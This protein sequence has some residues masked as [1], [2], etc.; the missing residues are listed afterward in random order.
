MILENKYDKQKD[1]LRKFLKEN[2]FD[3]LD[4]TNME[5]LIK[6]I[7]GVKLYLF[8]KYSIPFDMFSDLENILDNISD[9]FIYDKYYKDSSENVTSDCSI[10][11]VLF[12][13]YKGNLVSGEHNDKVSEIILYQSKSGH[14]GGNFVNNIN[15]FILGVHN[16]IN[17][18][19][20]KNDSS[21]IKVFKKVRKLLNSD[22]SILIRPVYISLYKYI[23]RDYNNLNTIKRNYDDNLGSYNVDKFE[24]LFFDQKSMSLISKLYAP[25]KISLNYSSLEKFNYPDSTLKS[26]ILFVYVKDF[27]EFISSKN[28]IRENLFIKNVRASVG[29]NQLN[30]SI[31]NTFINGPDK[32]KGDFWWIS[33]GITLIANDIN[34]NNNNQLIL[35]EPN[36]IN[37]QQTSRQLFNA[38]EYKD[39]YK[40]NP[41]YSPWKM[42]VKLFV[43]VNPNDKTSLN[44]IEKI[45]S[46]LNSQSG[47]NKNSIDLNNDFTMKVKSYL[48]TSN[49]DNYN[50]LYLEIRKGE[51]TKSNLVKALGTKD[52][53]L[54]ID[55]LSQYFLSGNFIDGKQVSVGSIRS[56]KSTVISQYNDIIFNY[57]S[58]RKE[59][60]KNWIM[61]AGLIKNFEHCF[62]IS[63]KERDSQLKYLK[64]ATF[65]AL[66]KL[67]LAKNNQLTKFSSK[68]LGITDS[69]VQKDVKDIQNE[70]I[71]IINPK[72]NWDQY[73]KKSEFDNVIDD[74]VNKLKV[75]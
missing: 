18:D 65:R 39:F 16:I 30:S 54:S 33:N 8:K 63:S 64:F 37:G 68:F 2:Y 38:S 66:I 12:I 15:S 17:L 35:K 74:V 45:I 40:N 25:N 51:Y 41:S 27:L 21:L 23:S 42:M 4:D 9:E 62:E 56:S 67:N 46:G 58:T 69:N 3:K 48:M 73:S 20:L 29:N 22:S 5:S 55:T 36:I 14:K 60:K 13:D 47:I 61:L 1:K 19:N 57:E 70:F 24:N 28:G 50:P 7:K 34:D 59:N 71:N 52:N 32:F 49:L 31:K 43:P 44:M 53:I 75:Q 72:E 6:M 10:D 11:G 26:Y